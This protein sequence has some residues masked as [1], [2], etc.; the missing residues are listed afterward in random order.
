MTEVR[1]PRRSRG[2]GPNRISG[3]R[4]GDRVRLRSAAAIAATLDDHGDTDGLP[5][6]PEMLPMCGQTFTVQARVNKTCDTINSIGCT[7]QMSETT[8]LVGARCDG[9]GHGGCQAGCLLFFKDAWLEPVD[10]PET[11]LEP[12]PEHLAFKLEQNAQPGPDTYRCQATQL[13]E[14]TEYIHGYGH[15]VEDL[16]SRTTT[17][18]QLLHA[19]PYILINK[20]QR[21]SQRFPAWLRIQNGRAF[22]FVDGKVRGR[23]PADRLDLQ[24]GEMVEVKSREEILAT[25]DA[26]QKNRGLWFDRE[27]LKYCGRR[28]RVLRRVNQIIDERTGQMRH[29]RSDC[30][31]L[32]GFVCDGLMDNLC[33][34][35]I[36]SYW[37]EIWL[38]RIPPVA[39]ATANTEREV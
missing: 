33:P 8:H 19:L 5:F 21:I 39:A 30:I 34:R 22:P 11:E 37:R 31:V 27:M 25:L 35:A 12:E 36:Y 29:I 16:R 26:N 28:A 13:L 6:M 20:Y 15:Y 17:P 3:V 32:E 23:T 2:S 14:A 9:S 7:R 38:R 18:A 1:I 10:E 24:P 4:R